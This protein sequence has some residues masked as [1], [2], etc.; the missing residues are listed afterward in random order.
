MLGYSWQAGYASFYM[1]L[2]RDFYADFGAIGLL[3]VIGTISLAVGFWLR[4]TYAPE[5]L[6]TDTN[7]HPPVLRPWPVEADCYSQLARV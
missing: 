4:A 6:Q 3:I 1:S 7:Q 2:K 5:W